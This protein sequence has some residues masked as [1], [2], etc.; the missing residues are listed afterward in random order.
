MKITQEKDGKIE[1][2]YKLKRGISKK[3]LAIEL[4][5]M[6]GLD[7]EIIDCALKFYDKMFKIK[8]KIRIE[9]KNILINKSNK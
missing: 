3:K 7:K 6:K 1:F 5:R 2:H 9:K 8:K 4:L